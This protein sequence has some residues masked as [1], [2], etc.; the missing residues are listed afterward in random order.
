MSAMTSTTATTPSPNPSDRDIL[1]SIPGVGTIVLANL[2]GAAG[3]AIRNR[4][5]AALRCLTGVAPGTTR[6]GNSCRVQRRRAANP[7]LVDS[8]YHW[9]RVTIQ[10]DPT[11]RQRYD[12]LRI[13]GHTHGRALRSVADRLLFVTCTMLSNGTLYQ[14]PTTES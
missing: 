11:S 14:K 9:T 13:R 2:L 1:A 4:D 7:W 12:A 5:D 3:L 6:S 8:S 10:Y